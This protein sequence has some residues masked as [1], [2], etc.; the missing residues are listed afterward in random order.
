[1]ALTLGSPLSHSGSP[2]LPYRKI[3]Y[4]CLKPSPHGNIVCWLSAFVTWRMV[5]VV[6]SHNQ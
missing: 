5:E 1:M 6:V 3:V 4:T 2:H